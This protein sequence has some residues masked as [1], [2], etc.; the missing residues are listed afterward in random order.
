MNH[1][2]LGRGYSSMVR[3]CALT[4]LGHG[5]R[6]GPLRAASA[7]YGLVLHST[8]HCTPASLW[9]TPALRRITSAS[10]PLLQVSASTPSSTSVSASA[11][12]LQ[13]PPSPPTLP[14]T[15]AFMLRLRQSPHLKV[16]AR[17]LSCG[18][19]SIAHSIVSASIHT[20]RLNTRT[21]A[22]S[23]RAGDTHNS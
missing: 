7:Q 12:A 9:Q 6:H 5:V 19:V 23:R 13:A 1:G 10:R 17:E 16:L 2:G 20:C 14:H 11:A 8:S 3:Q 4:R 21:H 22:L 18:V 15:S